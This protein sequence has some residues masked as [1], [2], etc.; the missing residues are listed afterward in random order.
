M[1]TLA[2]EVIIDYDNLSETVWK[3]SLVAARMALLRRS[4]RQ[5]AVFRGEDRTGA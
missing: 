1:A 2:R 5:S 4:W 3:L